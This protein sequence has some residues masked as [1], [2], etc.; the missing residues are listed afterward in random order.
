MRFEPLADVEWASV[1][2]GL[3]WIVKYRVGAANIADG[4]EVGERK[5]VQILSFV[6][7]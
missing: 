7:Y 1:S 4:S 2:G 6:A 5:A 3:G